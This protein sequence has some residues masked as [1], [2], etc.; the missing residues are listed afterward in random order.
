M[1]N[2]S[3]SYGPYSQSAYPRQKQKVISPEKEAGEAMRVMG[4]KGP[5]WPERQMVS[6]SRCADRKL[7]TPKELSAG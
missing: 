4:R 3:L 7:H 1:A 5:L 2:G 6:H